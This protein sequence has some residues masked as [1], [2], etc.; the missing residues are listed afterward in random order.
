[1][2][3]V[4]LVLVTPVAFYLIFIGEKEKAQ[5]IFYH[6]TL[7]LLTLLVVGLG[8][9]ILRFILILITMPDD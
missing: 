7:M 1:M 9:I 2:F 4:G 5:F 6:A 3:I 8:S